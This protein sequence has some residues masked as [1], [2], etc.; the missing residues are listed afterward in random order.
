MIFI[1]NN[2]SQFQ[3]NES[4]KSKT[5][6]I[7]VTKNV[8]NNQS[9]SSSNNIENMKW[10][11]NCEFKSKYK[12]NA[13]PIK[14]YRKQYSPANSFSNSS[15]IGFLDKPGNY[16]VT[17]S[18]S[19]KNCGNAENS[20]NIN[21]H[22]LE[23]IDKDPQQGD[24]SYDTNLKKMVCTACNPQSMVIKRATTVL[25]NSYCS[26]NREYLYRKC[27]TFD[28]NSLQ[29]KS[30]NSCNNHP[31]GCNPII[32]HSNKK[33]GITG[34][35]TSSSRTSALKYGYNNINNRKSI[36]KGNELNDINLCNNLSLKECKNLKEALQNPGCIGC[37]NDNKI[38][39]KRINILH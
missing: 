11:E 18:N 1:K 26:S 14:H 9:T 21:I 8:L 33:Y 3:K 32:Q 10:P 28:Q 25:D 20:Q 27:K 23:N 37:I 24:W 30:Y 38:R 34:P 6:N 7:I 2:R 22:I 31:F 35:I 13:N 16:I 15:I 4:W 12:F 19:C 5:N 17:N 29:T 36:I 39:R